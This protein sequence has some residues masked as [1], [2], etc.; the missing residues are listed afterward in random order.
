M[1]FLVVND[2]GIHAAGIK[3]LIAALGE[4][5]NVYVFAPMAQQS[6]K[7]HSLSIEETVPVERVEIP[8]AKEAYMVGGTPADCTHIGLEFCK[9]KGIDIDITFSG[10][11]MG[12][13]LGLD[14]IYS[15]TVGAAM[16]AAMQGCRGVAVSVYGHQATHFSGAAKLAIEAI[17]Y[18]MELPTN[19]TVNINTPD[20]EPEEFK[21]VRYGRL[22]PSFYKDLFAETTEGIYKLKGNEVTLEDLE[23]MG[24]DIAYHLQ[25]YATITPLQYDF[26]HYELL[27]KVKEWKFTI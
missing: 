13:N 4:V 26:T 19:V 23:D 18:I 21:G 9:K 8:G 15:G 27:E 25:G 14:T 7:S 24:L 22:G 16:E 5:G 20:T 10:I 11:N 3:A 12:C 1:N 6:G 2:D 17:P